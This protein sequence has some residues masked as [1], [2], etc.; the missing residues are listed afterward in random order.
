MCLDETK[1]TAKKKKGKIKFNVYFILF[2][3]LKM[4]NFL[5]QLITVVSGFPSDE[6]QALDTHTNLVVSVL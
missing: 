3:F 1:V 5:K 6:Y 2:I 4:L